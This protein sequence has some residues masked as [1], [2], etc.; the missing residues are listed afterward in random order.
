MAVT[1]IDPG[2]RLVQVPKA[3][4]MS[5]AEH[6][7]LAR[8]RHEPRWSSRELRYVTWLLRQRDGSRVAGARGRGA[9]GEL[10]F[11]GCLLRGALRLPC[12]VGPRVRDALLPG[13]DAL[14]PALT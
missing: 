2:E 14:L 3:L 4:D 1:A 12:G 6:P 13:D 5:A 8:S 9:R 11:R 10:P 7:T